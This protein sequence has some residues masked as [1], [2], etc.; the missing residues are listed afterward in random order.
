MIDD[1]QQ[2]GLVPSTPSQGLQNA[3]KSRPITRSMRKASQVEQIELRTGDQAQ[4]R[5]DLSKAQ[6]IEHFEQI[7][8]AIASAE[9]DQAL[10][11]FEQA[12]EQFVQWRMEQ[13]PNRIATEI[14]RLSE[15]VQPAL[16]EKFQ[17][18]SED[19]QAEVNS[20][21]SGAFAQFTAR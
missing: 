8:T 13:S 15:E 18:L 6:L 4:Q 16:A 11:V 1:N 2:S 9:S 14:S 3:P 5:Q 10:A 12:T 20:I 21:A 19:L 17:G 7:E